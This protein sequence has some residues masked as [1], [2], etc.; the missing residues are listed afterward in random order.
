MITTHT[1]QPIK[2]PSSLFSNK[3]RGCLISLLMT[4]KEA[5]YRYVKLITFGSQ[6]CVHLNGSTTSYSVKHE[7]IDEWREIMTM[8]L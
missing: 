8:S 6:F 7:M 4:L 5:Y 2:K 3:L 1:T